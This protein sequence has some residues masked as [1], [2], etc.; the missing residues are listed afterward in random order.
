[1][2]IIFRGSL[3]GFLLAYFLVISVLA[4]MYQAILSAARS[5]LKFERKKVESIHIHYTNCTTLIH[6]TQQAVKVE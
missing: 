1:M 2:K 4:I 3:M 5:G 6:R